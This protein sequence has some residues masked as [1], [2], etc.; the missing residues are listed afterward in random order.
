MP[1]FVEYI[2]TNRVAINVTLSNWIYRGTDKFEYIWKNNSAPSG[3][4]PLHISTPSSNNWPLLLQYN[5]YS[6]RRVMN[7]QYMGTW[8]GDS[9]YSY[10]SPLDYSNYY[11]LTCYGDKTFT[12]TKGPSLLGVHDATVFN[13]THGGTPTDVD[14]T[15]PVLYATSGTNAG[16][17]D[18][19][20]IK[21]WRNGEV[22]HD[23]RPIQDGIYDLVDQ[24]TYPISIQGYINGPEIAPPQPYIGF[25]ISLQRNNSETIQLTKDLT[26]LITVKGVLKTETSII[27]P[28]FLIECNLTDVVGCNYLTVPKFSR[29]YFVNDI[30]SIRDGL[31]AFTCHVDVL[32]SFAGEIRSNTGIVKRAESNNA[33]NLYINDGSLVAYQDPYILTEPFPNGFTG[34]GFILAVAGAASSSEQKETPHQ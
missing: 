23:Y 32:S 31:V 18:F 14:Y 19:F 17:F 30:R 7:I 8:S 9:N 27:N 15:P 10:D 25:S 21:V 12:M 6:S 2:R 20:G 16:D 5:L 3:N 1:T 4:W 28:V 13:I 33:Y 24:T 11:C 22:I 29:S 34:L 26:D